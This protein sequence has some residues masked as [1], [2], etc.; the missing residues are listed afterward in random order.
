MAFVHCHVHSTYSLLD[1]M[2]QIKELF[3]AAKE[4]GQPAIAITDHGSTSG[5]YEAWKIGN[6]LGVKPLLGTEFY[7]DREN[8][9][10]IGH[11]IAIAK[12]NKGL[13]NLFK[14][15]EYAYV[16]GF[17]RKPCIKWEILKEHHEGII[18]SSACLASTFAQL[19]LQGNIQ[20][21][22]EW[23]GKFQKVF[24]EDFYLEIQPNSLPEQL[25]VN[26]ATIHIA[27]QLGIEYI[28][29]ND[30]H[31]TYENDSFPHE[32]LLA[33]QTNKKMSDEKRWRFTTNDFWLKSE[34][35][36]RN[37][38]TGISQSDIDKSILSTLTLSQKPDVCFRRGT[39]HPKYYR[40]PEGISERQILVEQV[41]EGIIR[42]N[43]QNDKQFLRDVQHEIDVIDRNGYSG[44]FLI[45]S[46]Y[47]NT[48]R[49]NGI[50]VGDGRGSG[51]GSK[52]AWLIGITKIVPQ[53]Y[54]LL[55]ERFMADGRQPDFD[56]D[57]SDQDAIFEDLQKKYGIEN[58]ARIVAFG[59]MTPK[60]C[61]RKVFNVFEHPSSQINALTKKIPDDCKS[62]NELLQLPEFIPIYQKHKVEF[63]VIKR[64]EGCVSHE[65][66]HAGGVLIYPNLSSLLPI[67]TKAEDRTKRIVAFD[68]YM[69]EE[70]GH[71]K[72]D[73]LGLETLPIIRRTLLSIFDNESVR[74]NLHAIDY[75]DPNVYEML[76]QG[77]VS[78]V[79]QLSA[80]GQKVIE[81]QPRNFKDLIAINALIRPGVGDWDEYIARRK[82]KA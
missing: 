32:I 50:I 3:A 48:A 22:K 4:M 37:T 36:M 82:G 61:T 51:A 2:A 73:I 64:L 80:Q 33:L 76:C 21:A 5:L 16:Y 13:E 57:F 40:V 46:D 81:Q 18:V 19:I 8:D 58:V 63:D 20:S 7:Y 29:T 60:A 74:I 42:E 55:F 34:S 43:I 71:I 31:Y 67:K 52:V 26:Q 23:A 38:F 59:T 35:E 39:Y 15:Q 78:G 45:V 6:E 56:V 1:G 25:A 53:K 12:N 75:D 49:R 54:D 47:V 27:K 41:K 30:V 14:L 77:N 62:I 9:D 44:Y 11:I 65:G 10:G 69:L 28:A 68:K 72:F 70:L 24:G 79:F 17:H 66:Q